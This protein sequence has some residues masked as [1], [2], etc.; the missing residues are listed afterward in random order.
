VGKEGLPRTG[1]KCGVRPTPTLIITKVFEPWS[2]TG[3]KLLSS[4]GL[5]DDEAGVGMGDSGEVSPETS[6]EQINRFVFSPAEGGA[7]KVLDE[8]V[9]GER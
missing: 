4:Y 3:K 2:Q 5:G 9:R 8:R 7:E 1:V 6:V